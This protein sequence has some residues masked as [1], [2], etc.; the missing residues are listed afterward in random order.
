VTHLRFI[1][2]FGCFSS[3]C[4]AGD[5]RTTNGNVLRNAKVVQ[6]DPDGVV[7][8]HEA[9]IIKIDYRVLPPDLKQRYNFDEHKA[10]VF[11][12]QQKARAQ[13]TA[14]ENQQI[15][16]EHDQRELAQIRKQMEAEDSGDQISYGGANADVRAA[17]QIH[18]AM[19]AQQEAAAAARK[20]KT[21]WN[22]SVMQVISSIFGGGGKKGSGEGP[23]GNGAGF[24]GHGG[25]DR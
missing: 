21:F 14:Q 20:P 6:V 24:D 17:I 3:F 4:F 7:V 22:S 15:V 8:N 11:H 12:E 13:Q 19:D 23:I 5:L 25:F 16:K 1:L 10:A 18:K 2:F 9:G